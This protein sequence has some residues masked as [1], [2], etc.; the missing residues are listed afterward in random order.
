MLKQAFEGCG[1]DQGAYESAADIVLWSQANG[2]G[3]FD[4][5]DDALQQCMRTPNTQL[6]IQHDEAQ[7]CR[8]DVAGES[9]LLCAALL[10]DLVSA[11]ALESDFCMCYVSNVR[12]PI[13]LA[14]P[15][16]DAR[17]QGLYGMAYWI[18]DNNVHVLKSAAEDCVDYLLYPSAQV[19]GCEVG[20]LTLVY[21]TEQ[22]RM[23]QYQSDHWNSFENGSVSLTASQV[24]HHRENTLN[25]GLAI[26]S[27]LWHT[28]N[29]VAANVLVE[30]TEQS[31]MG[32]GA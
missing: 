12:D 18:R 25:H 7:S 23:E 22:S 6:T 10:S 3:G 27:S 1:L 5:L 20:R 14:K 11:K 28:L 9:I 2:F 15:L 19:P 13:L 26:T 21:A 4:C 16:V 17:R 32:A 24:K 31:R 8:V 29:Q 30:S